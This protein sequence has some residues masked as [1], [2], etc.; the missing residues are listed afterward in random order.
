MI[1][2]LLSL[3]SAEPSKWVESEAV[4]P[5]V[6]AV[7]PTIDYDLIVNR[8]VDGVVEALAQLPKYERGQEQQEFPVSWSPDLATMQAPERYPRKEFRLHAPPYCKACEPVVAYWNSV[9]DPDIG[10]EVV[11]A[12]VPLGKSYPCMVEKSTNYAYYGDDVRSVHAFRKRLGIAEPLAGFSVMS[13]GSIKREDLYAILA[14]LNDSDSI[15]SL[16]N[17]AFTIERDGGRLLV[18]EKFGASWTTKGNKRS[19]VFIKPINAEWGPISAPVTGATW[20]GGK[21][22]VVN[23]GWKLVQGTIQVED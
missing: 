23:T 20:D 2:I 15:P 13:L 18:P 5:Q 17:K 21:E 9:D 8:V 11:H 19:F 22:I 12:E 14:K 7:A 10:V 6:K 3:L 16:G 1:L 4:K